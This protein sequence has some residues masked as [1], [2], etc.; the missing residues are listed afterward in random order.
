M[1]HDPNQAKAIFLEAVE[2]HHPDQWPT[3]LDQACAGDLDLRCSVEVLLA[4]HREAGA[5]PGQAAAEGSAAAID[6]PAACPPSRGY[7][8]RQFVRQ[9]K[10]AL[11]MTSVVTMALFLVIGGIGWMERNRAAALELHTRAHAHAVLA[12]WAKAADDSAK[13]VE[14]QPDNALWWMERACYHLQAGDA[15]AYRSACQQMLERFGQTKNPLMAHRIALS[16]LLTPPAVNDDKLVLQLAEQSV[17]GA[18]DNPWC[19]I[20]LAAALYRATQFEAAAE[21]GLL[22]KT[23]PEDPYAD[24]GADGGPLLTWLVLAMAHHHLGHTEE[25]RGWLDRAAQRM[26]RESSAKEIGPLRQQSHVWA[27]C[28]VLRQEAQK[29]LTKGGTGQPIRKAPVPPYNPYLAFSMG[30]ALARK[31]SYPEASAEFTKA[32]ELKPDLVDAWWGRGYCRAS[33]GQEKAAITDHTRAIELDPKRPAPH[34]RLAWLLAT[35]A[36]LKLR[37]PSRAVAAANKAL[38]LSPKEG[39][40]WQT[41]AWAEYRAGNWKAALAA[42]EKVKALGSAGDSFQWFLLAMAYWQLGNKD[43]ARQWYDRAVEWMDKNKPKNDEL[44]RFR[45]EAREMLNGNKLP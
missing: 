3:F 19:S 33:L 18:P 29:L 9:N 5:A 34:D 7:R 43:Q 22:V 39:L 28:S 23:W 44:G 35:C 40:Y 38:A 11:L 26:D 37:D 27:M 24:A 15:A 41:L 14:L 36:D 32:I 42:M 25:A 16:C 21:L 4:A 30:R 10:V 8:L 12:E 13:A 20:T 45:T 17:A 31:G 6:E 1:N 2:K